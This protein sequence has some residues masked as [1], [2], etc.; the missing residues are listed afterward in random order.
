MAEQ[1]NNAPAPSREEFQNL[2]DHLANYGKVVSNGNV[3]TNHLYC[4]IMTDNSITGGKFNVLYNT[5]DNSGGFYFSMVFSNGNN[6]FTCSASVS[7]NNGTLSLQNA[8]RSDN[9]SVGSQ[10]TWNVAITG[11]R[12]IV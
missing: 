12:Q 9:A 1:F 3:Q 11:I 6:I 4:L 10:T 5:F 8:Y 2:A 7:L